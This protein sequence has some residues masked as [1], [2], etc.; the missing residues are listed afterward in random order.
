M[1]RDQPAESAAAGRVHNLGLHLKQNVSG[2]LH[3]LNP[4]RSTIFARLSA[5]AAKAHITG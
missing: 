2:T 1:L 4:I 5:A 3:Q